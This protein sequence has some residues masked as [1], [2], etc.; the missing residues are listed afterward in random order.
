[1]SGYAYIDDVHRQSGRFVPALPVV[2]DFSI[3]RDSADDKCSVT[4]RCF[5]CLPKMVNLTHLAGKTV[6]WAAM[7][8]IFVQ[9]LLAAD[10]PCKRTA[11][12]HDG[13]RVVEDQLGETECCH[14]HCCGNKSVASSRNKSATQEEPKQ[15]GPCDCP[16]T[17]PCQVRH[18]STV[19]VIRVDQPDVIEFVPATVGVLWGGTDRG[20]PARLSL[21]LPLIAP[22]P[23]RSS[24]ELCALLCR[25]TI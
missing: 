7:L 3:E 17:C 15:S 19:A 18:S 11:S 12:V 16:P 9:P 24:A 21:V 22:G 14:S 25:L 10:C 2:S 8:L 5:L 4:W 13:I 20:L 1:M 23:V 6:S